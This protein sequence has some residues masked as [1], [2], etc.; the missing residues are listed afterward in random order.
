[1]GAALF[2]QYKEL[3]CLASLIEMIGPTAV[4]MEDRVYFY[5]HP[6]GTLNGDSSDDA[7]PITGKPD[8]MF[9]MANDAWAILDWKVNG[10][11]GAK[12]KS[13][14]KGYMH[15][16]ASGGRRNIG[17]CHKECQLGTELGVQVNVNPGH[18]LKYDYGLQ[19]TTY[20]WAGLA[21]SVGGK[22]GGV[23]Y[24][25]MID[26]LC[27]PPDRFAVARHAYV[28][29]DAEDLGYAEEYRDLWN[30]VQT[31]TVLPEEAQRAILG[32]ERAYR[33]DTETPLADLPTHPEKVEMD[34]MTKMLRQERW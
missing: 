22:V 21:N 29:L 24:I 32:E 13:P 17:G 3:G 7:V 27:G 15:L 12:P 1:M 8:L 16:Y 14:D 18:R 11:F 19:T 9:K 10:M 30:R 34:V 4:I 20:L 25:K 5:L 33:E 23:P 6:D 28:G 26:Q 2:T 31:N